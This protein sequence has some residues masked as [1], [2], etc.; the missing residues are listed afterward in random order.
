MIPI[1]PLSLC[2]CA[3]LC[4][5]YLIRDWWV[6]LVHIWGADRYKTDMWPRPGLRTLSQRSRS[7]IWQASK[8]FFFVNSVKKYWTSIFFQ[9]HWEFFFFKLRKI[10][11]AAKTIFFENSVQIIRHRILFSTRPDWFA[12]IKMCDMHVNRMSIDWCWSMRKNWCVFS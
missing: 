5:T 9:C 3:C 7:H 8:N 6:D 12:S 11:W 4:V 2:L 10:W 1:V